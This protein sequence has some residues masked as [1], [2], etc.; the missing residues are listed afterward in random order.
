MKQKSRKKIYVKLLFIIGF[1]ILFYLLFVSCEEIYKKREHYKINAKEIDELRYYFKSIIPS[2]KTVVV[3]L[4]N[5]TQLKMYINDSLNYS[6]TWIVWN[7]ENNSKYV[8]SI[9]FSMGWNN[10]TLTILINKLEKADCFHI[11]TGEPTEIGF[12][13]FAFG[14]SMRSYLIFENPMSDKDSIFYSNSERHS[15]INRKLVIV[16][17]DGAL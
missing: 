14:L 2:K 5:K 4:E 8:D 6:P 11:E 9:L 1:S 17:D 12:D 16:I 10:K 7:S 13:K 15:Y 3:G